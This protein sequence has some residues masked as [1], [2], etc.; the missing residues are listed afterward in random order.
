[1]NTSMLKNKNAI[2]I[3]LCI[4]VIVAI[5]SVDIFRLAYDLAA[6]HQFGDLPIQPTRLV[7]LEADTPNVIGYREPGTPDRV[8]CAE[9]V[10]YLETS[11]DAGITRCCQAETKISCLSGDFSP[12][13]PAEDIACNQ[14]LRETFGVPESL[15]AYAECPDGGNPELTVAQMDA[16]GNITWKYLTVNELSIF[17]TVM[18]CVIAP[19]LLGLAIRLA[20]ILFRKPDPKRQITWKS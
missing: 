7:Y 13:I 14:T 17:N 1:M 10:A 9:A 18:R 3:L 11:G 5:Y 20:V 16:D 8:T 2:F 19:L 15:Q 12:D 4:L 6:W